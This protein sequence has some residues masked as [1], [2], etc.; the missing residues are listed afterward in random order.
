MEVT[1]YL[2]KGDALREEGFFES[3]VSDLEKKVKDLNFSNAEL[4]KKNEE[5]MERV[6]TLAS[7]TPQWPK[8]YRPQHR[9]RPN[10]KP[11]GKKYVN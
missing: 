8:G 3:K 4:V 11:T 2:D 5:L 9:R 7:R 6:K 1:L 10:H